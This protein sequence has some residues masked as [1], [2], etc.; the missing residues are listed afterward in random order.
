MITII[1]ASNNIHNNNNN[2]DNN[3]SRNS[4]KNININITI[5]NVKFAITKQRSIIPMTIAIL[6]QQQKNRITWQKSA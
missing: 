6:Q 2:N 5:S 1:V 4:R 3:T